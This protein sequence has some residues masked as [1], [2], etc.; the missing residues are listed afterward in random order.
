MC[1]T[2]SRLICWQWCNDRLT[3]G[4]EG[5][6]PQHQPGTRFIISMDLVEMHPK[7]IGV[8]GYCGG[9]VPW[10]GLLDQERHSRYTDGLWMHAVVMPWSGGTTKTGSWMRNMVSNVTI[11]EVDCDSSRF[12]KFRFRV[13]PHLTFMFDQDECMLKLGTDFGKKMLPDLQ[14]QKRGIRNT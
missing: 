9:F 7:L 14:C 10:E 8:H 2:F 4:F 6:L 3:T 13:A 1:F 5:A 12:S 11:L